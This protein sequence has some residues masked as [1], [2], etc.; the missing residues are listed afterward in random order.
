MRCTKL[1]FTGYKRLSN[2]SCNVDGRL[3]AFVGRNESGKSSLLEALAWFSDQEAGALLPTDVTHGQQVGAEDAI[4]DLEF[5]LD[6]SD[7]EALSDLDLAEMPKSFEIERRRNGQYA[8]AV[9]PRTRRNPEAAIN[10]VAAL[11]GSMRSRPRQY[12]EAIEVE[13]EDEIL[14]QSVKEWAELLIDSVG[15]PDTSWSATVK[16]AADRLIEWLEQAGDNG[17]ARDLKT[18]DALRTIRDQL[19]AP[20][21]NV[22]VRQR[23]E[24]RMPSFVL[25]SEE[26]RKLPTTSE[27]A[28]AAHRER[29]AGGV[30]NLIKLAELDVAGLAEAIAQGNERA[31]GTALKRANRKLREIFSEA[32]NQYG[33]TASFMTQG[34]QL[35]V[36]IDEDDDYADITPIHERSDGLKMF[37]ALVALLTCQNHARRPILLVDE[38]E[39][40]LHFDAQADLLEVMS[41][42]PNMEQVFYST[43][44][45]GCL[46]KDLGRGIRIVKPDPHN[47][48]RSVL[49]SVFWDDAEPGFSPLLMQMG[50]AGAAFSVCRQA[51]IGEGAADMV[52]LPTLIRLATGA[53]ELDYQVAPG[54]AGADLATVDFDAVAAKVVFLSDGDRAGLEYV[55]VLRQVKQVPSRR[56]LSHGEG[57][58]VEDY[59]D[60]EFYLGVIND[61]LSVNDRIT[62]RDLA[63]REPIAKSVTDWGKE[64]NVR[65]P[66]KRA[67]ASH[68][69]ENPEK[70]VLAKGAAAA[71][72]EL[73]ERI[74]AG[75]AS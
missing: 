27:I 31:C 66:G 14:E 18:A 35:K 41:R 17:K 37:V 68:I 2:T 21:P 13:T 32:W 69:V 29:I 61:F 8:T 51:V 39:N 4:L 26:D 71:L 19:V 15:D 56:V 74:T 36:M 45:P 10:A 53:K 47:E 62:P 57:R 28:Q 70:I 3:I 63:S 24:E 49:S 20:H 11:K 22:A 12:E 40:H 75:F 5:Y 48:Q 6:E 23:L 9:R 50:A 58:A 64:R 42:Y 59:L 67:V 60:A 38:A 1:T 73:H 55:R 30:R 52:L 43:H 44:S 7:R 16:L 65:V 46:P 72:R 54:L 34:T 25:F 33:I